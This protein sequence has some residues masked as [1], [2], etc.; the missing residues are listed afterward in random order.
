MT[1]IGA[2]VFL[3]SMT[4]LAGSFGGLYLVQQNKTS[5]KPHAPI[6]LFIGA[7]MASFFPL[8]I[9]VILGNDFPKEFETKFNQKVFPVL[10][11]VVLF[12]LACLGSAYSERLFPKLFIQMDVLF[13]YT[14]KNQKYLEKLTSPLI[15]DHPTETEANIA[16]LD[17]PDDVAQVLSDL[18]NGEVAY[19]LPESLSA[20]TNL[21]LEKVKGALK[22]LEGVGVVDEVSTHKG[23]RWVSLLRSSVL[24]EP[25]NMDD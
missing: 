10:E 14:F 24:V 23:A 7:L 1:G 17:L 19:R 4:L 8:V 12:G 15:E 5:D 18:Q 11:T 16:S 25:K 13:D 22:E 3:F 2:F 20:R 9:L 21:S 6:G